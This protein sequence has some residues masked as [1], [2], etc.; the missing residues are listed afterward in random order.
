M[1]LV[2][3]K[4]LELIDTWD[5]GGLAATGS[6][7]TKIEKVFVPKHRTLAAADMRGG[8]VPGA[9]INPNPLYQ[10]PVEALFPHLV[11]AP[12]I[13]MARGIADTACESMRSRVSTYNKSTVAGHSVPQL[14]LSDAMAAQ[15]MGMALVLANCSEADAVAANGNHWDVIDK[16]RWRRDAAYASHHAAQVTDQLH[17]AQGGGGIYKRNPIER[18]FRDMHAGLAHIGISNDVN[19][20]AFG[21]VAM[22]LPADNPNI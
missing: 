10:L 11:A 5:V 14:R 13:G 1:F 21:K 22:G 3:K 20:V 17:Q 6:L 2:P 12:V 18:M 9:A 15:D 19:G 16:H 8:A 4:E 7:D